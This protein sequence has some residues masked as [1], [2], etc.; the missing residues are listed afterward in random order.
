MVEMTKDALKEVCKHL[1][2]YSTPKLNDKLYLHFKGW[3]K[4]VAPSHCCRDVAMPTLLICAQI[5]N[6]EDFTGLRALW[7]ESNGLSKIEGLSENTS[8]RCL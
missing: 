6:L 5:K 3:D 4:V 7:L 8:L 1:D 2:L